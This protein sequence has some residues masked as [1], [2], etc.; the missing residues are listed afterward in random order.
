M[1]LVL[2]RDGRVGEAERLFKN[3]V[4]IYEN[5]LGRSS[6]ELAPVL[7]N[8][9]LVARSKRDY[10]N[11]KYYFDYA[12]SVTKN[13]YGPAHIRIAE[14]LN[15][16][17]QTAVLAKDDAHAEDYYDQ[18]LPILT[19]HN[20]I[21]D[22][23][24][25]V[26]MVDAYEGLVGIRERNGDR[27]N[28]I[29]FREAALDFADRRL[30][31]PE[32]RAAA[33]AQKRAFFATTV[34][35]TD[36]VLNSD[37]RSEPPVPSITR[38][39]LQTLIRRTSRIVDSSADMVNYMR[40]RSKPE[41]QPF[42]ERL[43]AARSE[44][45]TSSLLGPNPG[46]SAPNYATRLATLRENTRRREEELSR[47]YGK[48]VYDER[49][50]ML[51]EVQRSLGARQA[52]VA[53][54]LYRAQS[55]R[56]FVAYVLKKS[57]LARVDLGAEGPIDAAVNALRSGLSSSRGAYQLPARELHERLMSKLS[58]LLGDVSDVF[59][60]P[61][62]SLATI[63]FAALQDARGR[64]LAQ[65]LRI[66][67]LTSGRDLLRFAAV[68]PSR[69]GPIVLAAPDYDS[70]AN[71]TEIGANR[72]RGLRSIDFGKVWF[73]P[74]PGTADEAA[75]ISELLTG[76]TVLTGASA[77]KEAINNVHGP[78]ILHVATHGFFLQGPDDGFGGRALVLTKDAAAPRVEVSS[79]PLLRAGLAFA[80]A[81]YRGGHGAGI[82][83]ALE[84]SSLDLRG[85]KL[86]VLSA[87]ETGMVEVKYGDGAY[88]LRRAL[89]LSG[90]EAQ[91]TSLWKVDDRAT[92]QL[93]TDY[94][95]KLIHGGA[96][97]ESL[98]EVQLDMLSR[99]AR[100]HPFY[101][102]SFIL[103]GDERTMDGQSPPE[104]VPAL[105]SP[106]TPAI[107]PPAEPPPVEPKPHGCGCETA[108]RA[109][110]SHDLPLFLILAGARW[111]RRDPRVSSL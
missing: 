108:G 20:D 87:C 80:G 56:R 22:D 93:M 58:P 35:Q 78:S 27:T 7:S 94:Y 100:S 55:E 29:R 76:A 19:R 63:P 102:A 8:L 42:L 37:V 81:N 52:F 4:N 70:G 111:R 109:D 10:P 51:D 14:A 77:T 91:M 23:E 41:D 61:D 28:A 18:A 64:F 9:G 60:A 67:Y 65:S 2:F 106:A 85:T 1:G 6:P 43:R 44:L 107:P 39:A 97:G 31:S 13:A 45:A 66:T 75:A 15:Q 92:Q 50:I 3:T 98:R 11:A 57:Q 34:A 33:E 95:Q 12:L 46:E 40:K 83:T 74:L 21:E 62:G 103:A 54:A 99:P 96:R 71:S 53:I 48:V 47:K 38:L 82:L 59:L 110:G 5:R 101:W 89:T 68:A 24:A 84:A 104:V 72:N 32:F 73:P 30:L 26:G 36:A 49:S 69:S 16:L 79:D 86:V 88:G 17:G 90:A 105:W 25:L